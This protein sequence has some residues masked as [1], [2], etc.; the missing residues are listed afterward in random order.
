MV[1]CMISYIIFKVQTIQ[2]NLYMKI[3]SEIKI[4]ILNFF[5]HYYYIINNLK[6][7]IHT[8][9]N[10]VFFVLWILRI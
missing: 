4:Y 8:T 3:Y 5:Y 9:F 2:H 1:L 6:H 10:G 7:L